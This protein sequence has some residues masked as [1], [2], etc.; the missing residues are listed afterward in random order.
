MRALFK[1]KGFVFRRRDAGGKILKNWHMPGID[2][3]TKVV[4]KDCNHGWMSKLENHHAKPAMTDLILGK[5]ISEITPTQA[6]AIA[7]F[8]FKT[9]VIANFM[10]MGTGKP[11]LPRAAR[12]EFARSLTIPN[13]VQ[14]WLVGLTPSLGGRLESS[15][16]DFHYQALANLYLHTCTFCVGQFG[17]QVVTAKY[18]F[19]RSFS[20]KIGYE[21]LAVP[22]FPEIPQGISWPLPNILRA[23]G[24]VTNFAHRWH[25]IHDVE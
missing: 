19:I 8:A 14:M 17:F 1:S 7:L 20:P 15:Y 23:P 25:S 3:K 12:H 4:C 13:N 9:S 11:F 6:N 16:S 21:N 2:L 18:L 10:N 24:H 5:Q 22:F